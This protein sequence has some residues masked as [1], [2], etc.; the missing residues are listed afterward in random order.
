MLSYNCIAVAENKPEV[1][2]ARMRVII[3]LAEADLHHMLSQNATFSLIKAILFRRI[4]LGELYDLV[5]K[6][7]K[8]MITSLKP[9]VRNLCS[10]VFMEFLEKYPMG[11]KRREE[12][13]N[14]L[15]KNYRIRSKSGDYLR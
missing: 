15:L 2:D 4:I 8:L 14:A 10:Q 5:T 13:V 12:H 6:I 1:S 9:A 3:S 11:N 7:T